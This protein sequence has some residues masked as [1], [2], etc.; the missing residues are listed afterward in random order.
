MPITLEVTDEMI[1]KH[2]DPTRKDGF[3]HMPL[4]QDT[5]DTILYHKV[6][7]VSDK[8]SDTQHDPAHPWHDGPFVGQPQVVLQAL[9][10]NPDYDGVINVDGRHASSDDG[11]IMHFYGHPIKQYN[12]A[13]TPGG[14]VHVDAR[15]GTILTPQQ[16]SQNAVISNRVPPKYRMWEFHLESAIW[17]D[18]PQR[19]ARLQETAEQQRARSEENM[20]ASIAN[21]FKSI[22]GLIGG[23]QPQNVADMKTPQSIIESLSAAVAAGEILPEQVD[24]VIHMND[25]AAPA[26]GGKRR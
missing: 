12:G 4:T 19:N 22:P 23:G 3:A 8:R 7:A 2:Q 16:A 13:L 18:G 9:Q 14:F 20:A 6:E 17:T 1:E 5:K 15:A 21:A 10:R 11:I 25:V 24:A 26:G